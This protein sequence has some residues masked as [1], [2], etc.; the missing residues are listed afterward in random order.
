MA[1]SAITGYIPQWWPRGPQEGRMGMKLNLLQSGNYPQRSNWIAALAHELGHICG[2]WHEHQRPDRDH[3]VRFNCEALKGYDQAKKI[4]DRE[5]HHTMDEI[6][7]SGALAATYG[8]DMVAQYDTIEHIDPASDVQGQIW[9]WKQ[10]YPYHDYD[11]NSIM[12]YSS[13]A[14]Y[15]RKND[16]LLRVSLALWRDRLPDFVPPKEFT[17]DDLDNVYRVDKPS[18]KGVEGIKK[19]YPWGSDW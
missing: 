13:N 8:F 9:Y 1:P 15:W 5:G 10:N 14:H 17:K 12:C 4:S 6:C 7:A 16:E 19:L 11:D 18:P 3:Y 2:L